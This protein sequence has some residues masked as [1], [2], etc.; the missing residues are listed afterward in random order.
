[1]NQQ[2]HTATQPSNRKIAAAKAVPVHF[3]LQIAAITL[4]FSLAIIIFSQTVKANFYYDIPQSLMIQ[5]IQASANATAAMTSSRLLG[6]REK[7]SA[8]LAP[9]TKWSD[10]FAR[11]EQQM[12]N[13]NIEAGFSV[14]KRSL[15][16][17]QNSNLVTQARAIN[18]LMNKRPYINDARNWGQSDYWATPAE[19]LQRGGDCEDYAIAKYTALRML[20]VPESNLRIAIVQDTWKDIAH[21]VL[22]VY[23]PQGS[24]I[25]DNQ[26]EDIINGDIPGRYR[27]IYSINRQAWWLHTMPSA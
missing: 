14:L 18:T 2:Q 19:F 11:F 12:Q 5:P 26:N 1:M 4:L 13:P 8:R 27:P 7:S 3:A 17:L 23:T 10:M 15:Q 24:L 22:V 21:A 9:F 16:P 25:L 6:S 20:G